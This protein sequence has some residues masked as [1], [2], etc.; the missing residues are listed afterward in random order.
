M[1]QEQENYTFG[2]FLI[3]IVIKFLYLIIIPVMI[4]EIFIIV[5]SY[6]SPDSAPNIFGYKIFTIISRS[7]EPEINIDDVIFVKE[8]NEKEIFMGDI[9]TFEINDEIITHRVVNIEKHKD[10]IIYTTK[11]DSNKFTDV[12]QVEFWQIKGKYIWKIP[13]MGK[14]FNF[15]RNKYV[16]GV[17]IFLLLIILIFDRLKN[18][19]KQ[20]RKEKRKKYERKQERKKETAD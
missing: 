2:K 16:F 9:I 11:G 3:N 12:N 13:K 7:M 5:K 17:I 10:E 8:C 18:S 4:Y 20:K 19:K 1:K 15:L 6:K 14:L